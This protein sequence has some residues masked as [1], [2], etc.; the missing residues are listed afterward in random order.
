MGAK[1]HDQQDLHP[2]IPWVL[3]LCSTLRL[4]QDEIDKNGETILSQCWKYGNQKTYISIAHIFIFAI[5]ILTKL[6]LGSI[7]YLIWYL[8]VV[9]NSR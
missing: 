8:E 9:R 7:T 3:A 2:L 4:F 6:I 1:C 5:V